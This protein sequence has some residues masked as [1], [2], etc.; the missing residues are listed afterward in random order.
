MRAVAFFFLCLSAACSKAGLYDAKN[1]PIE[2][3][4]VAV[5]GVVCTEDPEL[6]KFPVKVVLVV[7]QTNGDLIPP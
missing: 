5:R 7:D 3:N 2:A 6:A 4:R 1:P